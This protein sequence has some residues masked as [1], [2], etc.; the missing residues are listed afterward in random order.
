MKKEKK[1]KK[2]RFISKLS[3]RKGLLKNIA[4]IDLETLPITANLPSGDVCSE[5]LPSKK[6]YLF[7]I[8]IIYIY[9]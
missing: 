1:F 3:E 4:V 6:F 2:L 7:I 8:F 5:L 9:Y